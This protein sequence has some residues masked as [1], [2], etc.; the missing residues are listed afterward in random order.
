M[1]LSGIS[2]RKN[3]WAQNPRNGREN[4]WRKSSS[5]LYISLSMHSTN[6]GSLINIC[7]TVHFSSP[8]HSPSTPS[9]PHWYPR[10]NTTIQPAAAPP[11]HTYTLKTMKISLKTRWEEGGGGRWKVDRPS[12][13]CLTDVQVQQRH[14]DP[15][16]ETSTSWNH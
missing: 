4:V 6:N 14:T 15:A 11:S 8:L 10:C 5:R 7:C 9:I 2:L 1:T 13:M 16:I 3:T 12:T